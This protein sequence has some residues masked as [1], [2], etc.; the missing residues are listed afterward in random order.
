MRDTL[1][2]AERNT[3]IKKRGE[4]FSDHPNPV[5][6]TRLQFG[7]TQNECATI[8]GI[9][10]QVIVDCEQGITM[11]P[12]PRYIAYLAQYD[13]SQRI[14]LS[15]AWYAWRTARRRD[16]SDPE[17]IALLVEALSAS[18]S[19]PDTFQAVIHRTTSRLPLYGKLKGSDYSASRY[20]LRGF[21][22]VLLLQTSIITSYMKRGHHWKQIAEAMLESDALSPALIEHLHALPRTDATN[23]TR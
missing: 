8:L 5:A 10:R 21:A 17:G 6:L 11:H 7:Y 13:P 3:R 15:D 18:T 22:R 19:P 16:L 12:N 14:A 2:T 4:R 1:E 23:V 9:T 20:N